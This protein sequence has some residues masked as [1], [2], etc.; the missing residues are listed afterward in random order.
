MR[1]GFRRHAGAGMSETSALG[2]TAVGIGAGLAAWRPSRGLDLALALG[3]TAFLV[4][5]MVVVALVVWI[6]DGGPAVFAHMRL[7]RDGRRFRC[8]KFR[9]MAVDAAARL[10]DLLA[11]DPTARAEWAHSQKLRRD[12]RITALGRFLR[13]SNLDE[14]PQLF[15]VLAGQMSLV[16][17]RPIVDAEVPRYGRYYRCYCA[18]RPGLTGLWQVSGRNDL[19]Y[20]RRVALD[21]AYTRSRSLALD[22][23]LL[24]LTVPAVLRGRGAY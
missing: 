15:N 13:R 21:V 19:S 7:G 4:P 17:P 11:A 18:V 3:L 12:P 14:L 23:K 10:A 1:E 5:L 16:G 8:L 6:H 9:S 20:R 24:A 2:R 22:L